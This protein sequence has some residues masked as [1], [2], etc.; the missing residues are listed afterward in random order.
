[1]TAPAPDQSARRWLWAALA[2]TAFKLWLTRGQD[3][4]ALGYAAHDDVLFLRLAETAGGLRC[5]A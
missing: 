4:F 5:Q 3:V 1:M 2:V